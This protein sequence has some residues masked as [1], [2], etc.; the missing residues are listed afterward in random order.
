MYSHYFLDISCNIKTWETKE[1]VSKQEVFFPK[2]KAL[3]R[4]E[5]YS[6]RMLR[7]WKVKMSKKAFE[8]FITNNAS[9][10]IKDNVW[11]LLLIGSSKIQQWVNVGKWL[12][13]KNRCIFSDVLTS[14]FSIC[15]YYSHSL[16]QHGFMS[17][18]LTQY[19]FSCFS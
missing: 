10:T 4:L 18:M 6:Q 2:C 1:T 14:F 8:K 3:F 16:I 9:Y 15:Y 19:N 12:K 5:T 13:G 11:N 17:F 7:K